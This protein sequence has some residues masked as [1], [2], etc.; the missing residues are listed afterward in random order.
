MNERIEELRIEHGF[1]PDEALLEFGEIIMKECIR[2][3]KARHVYGTLESEESINIWFD[4]NQNPHW[5]EKELYF[6]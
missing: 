1:M 2:A 4:V 3:C 5:K 6:G